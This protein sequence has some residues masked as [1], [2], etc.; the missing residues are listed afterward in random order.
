LKKKKIHV[1]P[2]INANR[3][4]WW[5]INYLIMLAILV[6]FLLLLASVDLLLVAGEVQALKEAVIPYC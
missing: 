4:K 2:I 3:R 6:G 1:L 5:P